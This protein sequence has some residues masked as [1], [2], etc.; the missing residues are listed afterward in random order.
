MSSGVIVM[1]HAAVK[2][3]WAAA[4]SLDHVG[5]R[6]GRRA[7]RRSRA[8]RCRA[9]RRTGP[10]GRSPGFRSRAALMFGTAPMQMSV[11]GC[12]AFMIVST[13]AATPSWMHLAGVAGQV[14]VGHPRGLRP[15]LVDWRIPTPTGMSRAPGHLE[16]P[17][18][19]LGAVDRVARVGDD[20]LHVELGRLEQKRQGPGVV[21]VAADVG[22]EN[23]GDL[24]RAGR[25]C[26]PPARALPAA[27]GPR[28]PGPGNSNDA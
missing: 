3:A 27:T 14:V 4:T 18:D 10:A 21:D 22:V 5:L 24:R 28:S 9:S 17:G 11:T 8:A 25:A 2:T 12:G 15:S 13:I 7:C 1:G 26:R 23:D 16:H 19:D 6:V 20:Q